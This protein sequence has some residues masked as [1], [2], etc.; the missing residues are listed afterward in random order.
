MFI[1]YYVELVLMILLPLFVITQL[2]IP[3]FKNKPI[4]PFFR[5]PFKEKREV[6]EEIRELEAT[7]DVNKL[8]KTAK[9]L[10]QEVKK[11]E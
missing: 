8:K 2:M 10:K 9:K 7:K 11:G 6:E 1:W 4:M 5:K 3:A